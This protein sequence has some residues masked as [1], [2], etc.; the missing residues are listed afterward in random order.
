MTVDDV[1]VE[2]FTRDLH[3][4]YFWQT[5]DRVR[6]DM[7]ALRVCVRS[8]LETDGARPAPQPAVVPRRAVVATADPGSEQVRRG[9]PWIVAVFES[10]DAPA[11][12]DIPLLMRGITAGRHSVTYHAVAT[13]GEAIRLARALCAPPGRA[14]T[15]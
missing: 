3:E 8:A 4:L 7:D 15:H 9:L 5:N 1:R 10:E 6:L 14:D 13:H 11:R 2:D 12:G